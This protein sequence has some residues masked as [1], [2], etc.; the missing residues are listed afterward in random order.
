MAFLQKVPRLSKKQAKLQ[1]HQQARP[2]CLGNHTTDQ[3]P[4]THPKPRLRDEEGKLRNL[5]RAP[6]E[7]FPPGFPAPGSGRGFCGKI[8]PSLS[9]LQNTRSSSSCCSNFSKRLTL[10]QPATYHFKSEAPKARDP[11]GTGNRP[12]PPGRADRGRRAGS[13]LPITR[14]PQQIPDASRGAQT[15]AQLRWV[16]LASQGGGRPLHCLRRHLPTRGAGSGPEPPRPQGARGA[17]PGRRAGTKGA[18]E[19]PR[20]SGREGGVSSRTRAGGRGK[21]E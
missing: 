10:I 12:P 21:P 9:G 20:P 16:L 11:P 19:G 13:K 1:L 4:Q 18:A 3:R 14:H 2:G 17:T 5:T 8:R 7:L 6:G 15:R